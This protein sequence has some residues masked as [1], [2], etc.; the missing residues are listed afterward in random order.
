MQDFAFFPSHKTVQS[1]EW[2]SNF[3][4]WVNWKRDVLGSDP[5]SSTSSSLQ[6]PGLADLP[7]Y[8]C[9]LSSR[10]H[11][12]LHIHS[13]Q[14]RRT[15][16][17]PTD[18]SFKLSS[19]ALMPWSVLG[20]YRGVLSHKGLWTHGNR[21]S[22]GPKEVNKPNPSVSW[23]KPSVCTLGQDLH[24]PWCLRYW[25]L[26]SFEVSVKE[27]QSNYKHCTVAII[28]NLTMSVCQYWW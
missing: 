19:L 2:F 6:R 15:G 28:R 4:W 5:L 20:L 24:C 16:T 3:S 26:P 9:T 11:S 12:V 1:E 18:C 13:Y 27:I 21:K 23:A 7:V 17:S 8:Y 25:V 10:Q 14:W 22:C